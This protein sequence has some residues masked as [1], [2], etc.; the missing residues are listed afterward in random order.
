[1][2]MMKCG[3]CGSGM[4]SEA[5]AC[6]KCGWRPS[7]GTGK[8]I[9]KWTLSIILVV[10][11]VVVAGIWLR[12]KTVGPEGWLRDDAEKA[13]R[14]QLVDP[15]SFVMRESYYVR[16][17]E[18]NGG[19]YISLCGIFDGKNRMGGYAG[20]AR[21]VARGLSFEDTFTVISVNLDN[22]EEKYTSNKV[23]ML[24]PFEEVYWNG[25]CVDEA[26]PALVPEKKAVR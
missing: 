2:A 24:S 20:G 15:N 6:P 26:H 19:T 11:V 25:F 8:R 4:S 18:K 21:F 9:L 10:P 16:K 23:G 13:I 1:M 5:R 3:E 12:N 14:A 22:R 7:R 17:P